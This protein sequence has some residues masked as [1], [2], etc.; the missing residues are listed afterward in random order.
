LAVEAREPDQSPDPDLFF[1]KDDLQDVVLHDND[2]VVILVVTVG[3]RV[4]RVLVNQRSS[5][6]VMFWLTFNKFPLLPD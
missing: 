5:T 4:H 1:M 6:D 2:P 3:R